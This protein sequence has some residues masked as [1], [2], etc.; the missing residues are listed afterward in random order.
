MAGGGGTDSEL[1]LIPYMDI[2]VNLI[3]FML[4]V[5]AY[6]VELREAPVLAPAYRSGDE[7]SDAPKPKPY[8]SVNIVPAGFVIINSGDLFPREDIPLQGDQY[9][10]DQLQAFLVNSKKSFDLSPNLVLAADGGIPYKVLVRTMDVARFDDKG[11]GIFPG[12]TLA[13]AVAG[14]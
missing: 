6:I 4:V 13:L 2:M 1:N 9:P 14:K 8:L 5:T 12:V 3:M 7:P 10:Y 11:E